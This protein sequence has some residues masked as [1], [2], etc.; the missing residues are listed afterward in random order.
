MGAAE[1][2]VERRERR[3]RI[4]QV[5]QTLSDIDVIGHVLSR[6][7]VSVGVRAGAVNPQVVGSSPTRG[8]NPIKAWRALGSVVPGSP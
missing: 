1:A 4:L 2:L 5:S 7:F 8:A 6:I 3:L